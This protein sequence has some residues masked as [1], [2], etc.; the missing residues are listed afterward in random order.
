MR[1]LI[2]IAVGG[3]VF[4]VVAL[5]MGRWLTT[6]S[7]ERNAVLHLLDA[8]AR[9]DA[10]AMLARMDSSCRTDLRCARL[11]QPHPGSL[12]WTQ[13]QAPTPYGALVVKWS[14]G[15]ESA[16]PNVSFAMADT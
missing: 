2:L 13:G 6:E 1:R 5:L 8:Q 4:V 14:C 11:V 16:T 12:A 10:P 15:F 9:G 3:A 7:R